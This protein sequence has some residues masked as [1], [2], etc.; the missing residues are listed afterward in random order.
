MKL[1]KKPII[2]F[3]NSNKTYLILFIIIASLVIF[4]NYR[5]T[6]GMTSAK[7]AARAARARAAQFAQDQSAQAQAAQFAKDQAARDTQIA[8]EKAAQF[9]RDMQYAQ[10]AQAQ[11]QSAR[12]AQI[13]QEKAAQFERD[14]QYAQEAQA[15]EQFSQAQPLQ[16][17]QPVQSEQP[18]Q[19]TQQYIPPPDYPPTITNTAINNIFIAMNNFYRQL[20]PLVQN[21]KVSDINTVFSNCDVNDDVYNCFVKYGRG[22]SSLSPS[23]V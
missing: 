21:L 13:A 9:E 17:I 7:R 4:M 5:V 16:P 6:E 10:E 12:D 15:Q 18:T 11:E 2:S 23:N 19:I 1:S 20:F 14:M 22:Q 8:Q 3:L